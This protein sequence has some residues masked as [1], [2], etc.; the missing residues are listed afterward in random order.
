MAHLLMRPHDLDDLLAVAAEHACEALGAATVSISRIDAPADVVRTMINVGDLGPD[1]ER[2]PAAESYPIASD[3]RLRSAMHELR[4]WVDSVDYADCAPHERELLDRLGKGCSLATAIVVDGHAWGEFYA[5][6]HR[7]ETV[8]GDDAIAYSQVLVAILAS[9]ISRTLRE[10]ELQ[11]L[12]FH[13]PLTGLLNRRGLDAEAAEMFEVPAGATRDVAVVMVDINGLKGIN[14]SAG[15]AHGDEQIRLVATSLGQAFGGFGSSVVARVGGD[16]FTV[17]VAD[18]PVQSV[19]DATNVVCGQMRSAGADFGVSAGVAAA[20]I[21]SG[22]DVRTIGLFAAADR[23][24]YVA[25]RAGATSALLYD[26]IGD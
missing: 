16:E 12:A 18:Q 23:A 1:E 24:Q 8:F 5:T 21:T 14:D 19:L 25:K 26:D 10:A 17:L 20:S 9:A 22:A 7:G 6:R 15:H 13:D 11:E 3:E 4:T 2:W